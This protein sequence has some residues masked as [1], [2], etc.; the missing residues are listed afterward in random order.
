MQFVFKGL[1]LISSNQPVTNT[2]QSW[3]KR[4]LMLANFKKVPKEP[5]PGFLDKL[6]RGLSGFTNYLLKIPVEEISEFIV[7]GS[8]KRSSAEVWDNMRDSDS[9][10]AWVNDHIIF[11][12]EAKTPTGENANE[13]KDCTPNQIATLYGHYNYF[14]CKTNKKALGLQNFSRTLEEICTQTLKM[15]V[16]RER[17]QIDGKRCRG[18]VGL[19]IR[20]AIDPH[21]TIDEMLETTGRNPGQ[22][23]ESPVLRD[24]ESGP[25]VVPAQGDVGP[26]KEIVELISPKDAVNN[27]AKQTDPPPNYKKLQQVIDEQQRVIDELQQQINE[28]KLKELSRKPLDMDGEVSGV[29]PTIYQERAPLPNLPIVSSKPRG[30]GKVSENKKSY[31]NESGI[32]SSSQD[33]ATNNNDKP[34]KDIVLFELDKP[35]DVFPERVITLAN[36]PQVF[37]TAFN[38]FYQEA[39]T[40]EVKPITE[41][42]ISV[43]EEIGE[44]IGAAISQHEEATWMQTEQT[45][46]QMVKW[47]WE[48]SVEK[49]RRVVDVK[50]WKEQ[51]TDE[52]IEVIASIGHTPI[53]CE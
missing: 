52:V 30:F 23:G 6:K 49:L 7:K 28:Q 34:I 39:P 46:I 14:C 25:V 19:R 50:A 35:S 47:C 3:F 4:R 41:F 20:R 26:T 33:K 1:V 37:R 8:N 45:L 53:D 32:N 27:S 22:V 31:A 10:A 9:L 24:L 40:D 29:E 16:Y 44:R 38:Q 15:N 51:I 18:F 48:E 5:D 12:P 42:D 17:F 2:A 13:W 43:V 36:L 21:P 11:D